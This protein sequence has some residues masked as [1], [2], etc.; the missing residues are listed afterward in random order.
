MADEILLNEAAH[1]VWQTV[2]DR[3][4]IESP[5]VDFVSLPGAPVAPE[6]TKENIMT[7]FITIAA[8]A[9]LLS[10]SPAAVLRPDHPRA[11]V[12]GSLL[13]LAADDNVDAL[14]CTSA[15]LGYRVSLPLVT[16]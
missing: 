6:G 7:K 12:V 11:V 1:A 8:A 14:L 9:F 10:A 16:K 3:G 13:G 15:L 4:P 5:R 2:R